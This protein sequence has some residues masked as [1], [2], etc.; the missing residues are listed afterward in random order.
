M[1]MM[2]LG[3]DFWLAKVALLL[4]G[5]ETIVQY[6]HMLTDNIIMEIKEKKKRGSQ[7]Y[8]S[9]LKCMVI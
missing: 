5:G 6:E 3:I 9:Y 1:M 8:K 4:W 7:I 2:I